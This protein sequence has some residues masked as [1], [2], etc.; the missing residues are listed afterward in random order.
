MSTILHELDLL[1]P[2]EIWEVSLG[3]STIKFHKPL[4]LQPEWLPDDPD[5]PDE[6]E[7]LAVESPLLGISAFGSD[8][9]E[10]WRFICGDI[11]ET[12]NCFVQIP[13]D[14]LSQE[15]LKIKNTYLSIAEE[16]SNE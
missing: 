14:R 10:L 12:W 2:F 11:R 13:D 7:Y 4:V 6:N 8:R 15:G 5:D 16:V 3:K 1:A 9:G